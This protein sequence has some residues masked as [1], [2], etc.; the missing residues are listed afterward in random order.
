MQYLKTAENN[1]LNQFIEQSGYHNAVFS[2]H[3]EYGSRKVFMPCYIVHYS[4]SKPNPNDEPQRQITDESKL[5][6]LDRAIVNGSCGMIYHLYLLYICCL[7]YT[8]CIIL[9][10][11]MFSNT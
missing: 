4:Q 1:R 5:S 6:G 10:F 2:T 9:D 11:C 3:F 8:V 7:L